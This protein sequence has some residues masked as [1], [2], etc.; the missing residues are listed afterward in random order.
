MVWAKV[1]PMFDSAEASDNYVWEEDTVWNP[2]RELLKQALEKLKAA[3][4]LIGDAQMSHKE[5][6]QAA[7]LIKEIEAHLV[8]MGSLR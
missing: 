2:D 4:A 5:Y 8:R 6:Y 3:E 7:E 1:K